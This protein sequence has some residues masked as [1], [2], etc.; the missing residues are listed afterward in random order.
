MPHHPKPFF[1]TGRGWYVQLG[2]QQVKLADGPECA[3]NEAVARKRYHEVMAETR[4]TAPVPKMS[5]SGPTIA[6]VFKKFLDWTQKHRATRTYEW[7]RDH[8]QDFCNHLKTAAQMNAAELRPFHVVEWS[9]S[10]GDAWSNA[11]RRGGIIAIQRP[12]NWAEELGYIPIS[13]IK[14]IPKPQPQRRE[15][16]VSTDE[17]ARIRDRY[18]DGDPFRDLLEFG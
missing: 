9:D 15:Q 3:Q 13:P 12:F 6:E 5:P 4:Q 14:K 1:R 8:I 16:T 7:Y 11:Y 18:Q 2:K 10:H 17:W